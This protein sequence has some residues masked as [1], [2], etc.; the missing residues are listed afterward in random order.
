MEMKF[1]VKD[2]SN[3]RKVLRREGA[4][5]IDKRS[6]KYVYLDSGKLRSTRGKLYFVKI[7]K[8]RNF[9]ELSYTMIDRKTYEKKL[10]SSKKRKVVVNKRHIY[11]LGKIDVS[12]NEMKAGKFVILDGPKNSVAAAV[13]KLKLKDVVKKQF[14]EL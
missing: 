1:R 9:F 13:R 3:I 8:K 12:L 10:R 4:R 5:L 11:V 14:S 7:K 6:E 2:F